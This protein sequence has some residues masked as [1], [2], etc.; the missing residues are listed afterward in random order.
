MLRVEQNPALEMDILKDL[1]EALG[2][3][4]AEAAYILTGKLEAGND[5]T[6]KWW[7]QDPRRASAHGE[8]PQEQRSGLVN[9][10]DYKRAGLAEWIV[11]F[12]NENQYKL[13]RLEFGLDQA[14]DGQSTG[15]GKRKG[16]RRPLYMLFQGRD[17]KSTAA[18][19]AKAI[20]DRVK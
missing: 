11:G 16:Q 2:D 14:S 7:P 5:R 13:N 20:Q 1:D 9:S 3:A 15:T 17:R 10:V 8:Y 19:M 12:F 18:A 6:G 4:S